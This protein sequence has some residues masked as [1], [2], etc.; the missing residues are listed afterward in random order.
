MK[1]QKN[2]AADAENICRDPAEAPAFH[3]EGF[4]QDGEAI[5]EPSSI[6]QV[7]AGGDRG[8]LTTIAVPF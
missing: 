3:V 5:P 4:F 2:D 8:A 6:E 7:L 1:R